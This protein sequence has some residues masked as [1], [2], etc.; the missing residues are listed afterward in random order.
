MGSAMAYGRAVTMILNNVP[1][2]PP[3]APPPPRLWEAGVLEA[4]AG[5]A[6]LEPVTTFD[7]SYAFEYPDAETLGRLLLA[8]MGLAKLAG[9]EREGAVRR[10]IVEALAPYRRGDGSYRLSNEFHYVVA[11]A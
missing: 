5:D 10:E 2:P 1:P 11:R 7:T 4:L 6:G 8:P 3:D 9:P